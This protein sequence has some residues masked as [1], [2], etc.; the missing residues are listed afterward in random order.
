MRFSEIP[1]YLSFALRF[2]LLLSV[3][4]SLYYQLWHLASTSIFLLILLLI[5]QIM[6]KNYKV[7]IPVEFEILLFFFVV[8]SLIFGKIG[9]I[10]TPIFFGIAIS[11][12]GFMIML[13]LYS[14]NQ[15]KKNYLL[16]L[17]FSFNFAVAFGFGIE[18]LKYYLKILLGHEL[19][20]GHYQFSMKNMTYVII[21]AL[22]ASISGFAYM[23]SKRG[24]INKIV[25]KF[26]KT[27]PEIFT[28]TDSPTE[29]IELIKKGEED[30]TEFKSTL[31]VNLHTG[32]IDKR[33]E[34]ATLKTISA[35][36]NSKGG[37]LLLG[38]SNNGEVIGLEKD[39]FENNDRL[40]LHLTNLVRGKIGKHNLNLISFKTIIIEGKTIIRIDCLKSDKPVFMMNPSKEEEFYIRI[41]PS[42]VQIKGSELVGYISKR[43]RKEN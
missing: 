1:N 9:G 14:S 38:V 31:R 27:N 11:F 17:L 25:K 20:L 6:K 41:G 16:V 10:V 42:S 21:G 23:K 24:L 18:F 37:T 12:I 40:N 15:I 26:Q 30:T 36:L 29:I 34:Y 7:N 35:F 2:I 4:N 22:F 3:I 8:A 19:T 32:E 28:K 5:P 43:F 39:R 33:I 13:I